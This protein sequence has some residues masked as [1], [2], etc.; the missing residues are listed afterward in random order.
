MFLYRVFGLT[1]ASELACPELREGQGA[2]DVSCVCQRARPET[3]AR[4]SGFDA[5]PGHFELQVPRVA[6]FVVSNGRTI[7]IEPHSDAD[8][9]SI[10]LFLLGTVIGALLHQRGVL[11]L[12]GSA[13]CK[14]DRSVLILGSSGAGKS[15]LA[16]A[17]GRHGWRLQSDDISALRLDDGQVWCEA[18]FPRQKMWPDS[19]K[20]LGENPDHYSRVRPTLEKR[21]MAVASWEFHDARA[22]ICAIVALSGHRDHAPR[23]AAVEGPR[24]MAVLKRQTFRAQLSTRLQMQVRHFRMIGAL[25]SQ[26]PLWRLQRPRAGGSPLSLAEFL[27][28]HLEGAV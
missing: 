18:G 21:N 13:V 26:A 10:R 16:A 28:P 24:R 14:D 3:S 27:V 19:L 15:S 9:D 2:P 8:E 5:V 4:T 22:P 7:I 6:R 17:L 20:M 11:P 1:L 23:L 25:A 12:H